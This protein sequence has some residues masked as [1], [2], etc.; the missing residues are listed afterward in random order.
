M[1]LNFE[2]ESMLHGVI[3]DTRSNDTD[4]IYLALV[5]Y[6]HLFA[7][8][9]SFVKQFERM[10][11]L[12]TLENLQYDSS[13]HIIKLVQEIIITYFGVEEQQKADIQ[14]GYSGDPRKVLFPQT[15]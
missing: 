9:V 13:K 15:Y 12:S 6:Q 14:G 7:T 11:A 10:D 4:L 1:A 3:G 5:C 8:D 2:I